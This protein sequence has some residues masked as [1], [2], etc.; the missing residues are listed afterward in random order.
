MSTNALHSQVEKAFN[1]I[2]QLSQSDEDELVSDDPF[3]ALVFNL[4][5]NYGGTTPYP[6]VLPIAH[7]IDEGSSLPVC[8]ITKDPH[9]EW[10]EK[11]N[12]SPLPY[13]IKSYTIS[14]W[15]QRFANASERRELMHRFRTFIAD[16]RIAHLLDDCIGQ[17]FYKLKRVP[18]LVDLSGEDIFT[19]IKEVV[20][21][22]TATLP[23]ANKFA[24]R[25]GRL[26]WEPSEI[27][28][29]AVDVVNAIFQ[30]I[31]E[32]KVVTISIRTPSS[33]I[34]PVYTADI[35]N[36]LAQE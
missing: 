11:F 29:N 30:K 18:A 6:I 20:E 26:S 17:N 12:Q 34:L 9:D 35:T 33:L 4:W 13:K 32:D 5:E 8:V 25:I 28:D 15:R 2:R 10:K 7:E 36:I 27:A 23:K 19:P 14:T 24:V 21:G 1:V 22:T 31:G 16:Q 3:V